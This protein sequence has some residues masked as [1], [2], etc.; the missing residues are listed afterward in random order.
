[1]AEMEVIV[2]YVMAPELE[3]FIKENIKKIKVITDIYYV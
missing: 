1:V 2:E 3:E